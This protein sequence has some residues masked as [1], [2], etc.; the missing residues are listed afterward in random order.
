MRIVEPFPAPPE[1]V[2]DVFG[3]LLV[4]AGG[5]PDK[6]RRLPYADPATGRIDIGSIPRPWDPATCPDDLRGDLWLWLDAV[7][8]WI[9]ATYIWSTRGIPPCW[10]EHPHIAKELASIA[11]FYVGAGDSLNVS[12]MEEWHRYTLPMFL[13]RLTERLGSGG[14]S[15]GSHTVPAAA[16]ARASYHGPEAVRSRHRAFDSDVS[17][18]GGT[19]TAPLPALP[20]PAVGPDWR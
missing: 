13:S 16:K 20:A 5:D 15:S 7:A 8:D 10:P 18:P 3:H 1:S 12:A 19:G 17:D 9:N 11:A 2:D 6:I 14:C 4:V